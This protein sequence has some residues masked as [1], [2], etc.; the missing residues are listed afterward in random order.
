MMANKIGQSASSVNSQIRTSFLSF[1]F[2]PFLN[3]R[4][5]KEMVRSQG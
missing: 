4:A 1:L 5:E 3:K 2:K